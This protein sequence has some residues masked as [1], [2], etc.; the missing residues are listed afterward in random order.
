MDHKIFW[1]IGDWSS[2]VAAMPTRGPLPC[3]TVLVPR[4]RVAHVL[5]RTWSSFGVV[6]VIIL[7]I[8]IRKTHNDLSIDGRD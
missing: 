5:R 4:E 6:G 3:R 2:A 1:N 8:D 7:D